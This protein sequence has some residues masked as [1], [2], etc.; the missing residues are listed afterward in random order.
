MVHLPVSIF[1]FRSSLVGGWRCKMGIILCN[2]LTLF[3]LS[4][5]FP[6]ASYKTKLMTTLGP[7]A[8]LQAQV[9]GRRE[10]VKATD[11]AERRSWKV[12]Y[13]PTY[14]ISSKK[15]KQR[16][17]DM[18]RLR[19]PSPHRLAAF[20]WS[21]EYSLSSKGLAFL[22]SCDIDP[23]SS[24]DSK[25]MLPWHTRA[26]YPASET[27]LSFFFMIPLRINFSFKNKS[28][29]R[30]A[31]PETGSFLEGKLWGYHS[32]CNSSDIYRRVC[33][34]MAFLETIYL[35]TITLVAKTDYFPLCMQW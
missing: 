10:E 6:I 25:E 4:A 15:K 7:A 19:C 12:L 34:K 31:L 5:T 30:C 9:Q 24:A 2:S 33:R 27:T 32:F 26:W 23:K 1:C 3:V 22:L 11:Q 29:I 28:N 8:E 21:A 16:Y 14:S 20:E 13:C 35:K 17:N 18:A